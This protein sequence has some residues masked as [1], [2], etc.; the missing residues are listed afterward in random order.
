MGLGYK[1]TSDR[2]T[3]GLVVVVLVLN[4]TGIQW[5]RDIEG[6]LTFLCVPFPVPLNPVSLIMSKPNP[7]PQTYLTSLMR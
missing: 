1:G 7:K 2:V 5:D 3:K 4:G 6:Q